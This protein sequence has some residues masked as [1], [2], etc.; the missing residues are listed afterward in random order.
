MQ[1]IENFNT[2]SASNPNANNININPSENIKNKKIITQLLKNISESKVDDLK[3]NIANAYHEDAEL[4]CF[5]PINN[6]KGVEEIFSK[7][8]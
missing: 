2:G 5:H 4:K 1:E 6:I 8:W 3:L 7:I